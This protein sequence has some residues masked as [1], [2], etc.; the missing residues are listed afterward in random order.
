MIK[1]KVLVLCTGNSARSQMSEGLINSYYSEG[2]TAFSAGTKPSRLNPLA[3]EVMIEL[4]IDISHHKSKHMRDFYNEEFDI[5]ITVCD[6][7]KWTCPIFPGAKKMVHQA[8]AD[9]STLDEFRG[10]RDE[11]KR[12]LEENL[13]S[14]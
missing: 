2:F 7:A 8:F 3:V 5:V 6:K 12:W 10:V 11:I 14:L 4:G 9:P 13:E 1:K